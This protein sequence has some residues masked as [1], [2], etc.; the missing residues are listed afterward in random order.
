MAE[1]R[2]GFVF[3]LAA[4]SSVRL[5]WEKPR[6]TY[7]VAFSGQ[8]NVLDAVREEGLEAVVHVAC[9]AEEYGRVAEEEL[10]LREDHPLAPSSPYAL[11][12]VIQDYHALFCHRAYG[13]KVIRTR[14]FNMTGPGQDSR[15]VVSDFARQ[16][17]EVEAGRR[18]PVLRVGN[19]EARRDFC[20]VRDVVRAYWLLAKKGVPGEVYNVCAGCDHSIR[21]ILD[22]LLSLSKVPIRVEVDPARLR[23]ADIPVLRGDNTKLREAVGWAPPCSL[24]ETLRAVLDWW[25]EEVGGGEAGAPS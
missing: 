7:Q 16:I 2:P 10:P 23:K 21:E 1:F 4:Q 24:E 11:S 17:A 3:H 6:L 9:S 14:A 20:D 12:K 25:R 13:M 18:E 22:L 5:S 19:L 8:S 15:F